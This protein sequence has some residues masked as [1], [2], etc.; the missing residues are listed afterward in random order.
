MKHTSLLTLSFALLLAAHVGAQPVTFGG[1]SYN[2]DTVAFYP[3]GPGTDY[4]KLRMTRTSTASYPLDVFVMRVDTRNPYVSIEQELGKNKVVGTERPSAMAQRITTPT[5]IAFAGTN[6]DFFA[7]TGDVGRPTGLTIENNEYAYIGS[8]NRRVGAVTAAGKPVVATNW[9]Y[10]G[11]LYTSGS[12]DT[13]VIKHVNYSRNT[14]ELVLYN[15]HQGATTATNQYGTELL[16]RLCE[17]EQ[18][19]THGRQKAVVVS[20]EQNKGSMAIPVGQAVLSG[21]GVMQKALDSLVN[22]G[23]TVIIRFTLKLDDVNTNLSQAIG[24]D[25]YALILDN[26]VAETS[27]FWNEI[28]PRTGY[29]VSHTGDT[30][31]FCVVDGR[32]VQSYGCTTSVLG[33]IMHH[34]GAWRAVNWDGGGSS[35]MYVR[36]FGNQVNN[37]S[38][39]SE[40]A[41][42]NAMF[43]VANLPEA[44]DEV[45]QLVPYYAVYSLPYCGFYTPRFLGYNKYGVMIDTDVQGVT[46]SCDQ[47]VGEIRDNGASFFASTKNGGTLTAT[48]GSATTEIEIRIVAGNMHLKYDSVV[49]DKRSD[50]QVEVVNVNRDGEQAVLAPALSWKSLNEDICTINEDGVMS[51][52]ANGKA[53]VVGS[54]DNLFA[55]TMLVSVETPSAPVVGAE[56]FSSLDNW[57]ITSMSGFNPQPALQDGAL[58]VAFNFSVTRKPYVLFEKQIRFYGIPDT[59]KID[60]D[61]D[62]QIDNVQLTLS[63]A[64]GQNCMKTFTEPLS[65]TGAQMVVPVADL[66]SAKESK[67]HY[68][69]SFRQLRFYLASST[70]AGAHYIRLRG[71]TLCYQGIEVTAIDGVR[72]TSL[73]VYPVPAT[74]YIPVLGA[75]AGCP[76]QLFTTDGKC[77]FSGTL[78]GNAMLD[79]H[80]AAPGTYLLQVNGETVKILKK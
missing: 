57:D 50:W 1:V 20:K 18:W 73:R 6:G 56:D 46:L 7:T 62:A 41:V 32:T 19:K 33:E 29:G 5:H 14:D 21:H 55:D 22:V 35:S 79:M 38:D 10:T 45:A 30:A 70:T 17:G 52:V 24:G 42:G 58:N 60:Y 8:T 31:V 69:L 37:G 26:G 72:E 11:R 71:I 80:I 78:D 9:K 65:G 47:S 74:D 36:G 34:Y 54:L 48:K 68:P 43:V 51:A 66:L 25:N 2:I 53:Q 3:V 16:V 61:T 23:D 77:L 67:E 13:L 4:L 64:A 49:L 12:K 15:Q 76:V 39:G 27:N 44:D 63:S 75:E 59:I 28:H 40:R